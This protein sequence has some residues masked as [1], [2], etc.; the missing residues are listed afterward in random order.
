MGGLRILRDSGIKVHILKELKLHGKMLLADCVAAI[1]GS[2][3][4]A[5]GSL[6]SRRELGI[7]IHDAHAVERLQHIAHRDWN[8]SRPMDLSDEGLRDDLESRV[9]GVRDQDTIVIDSLLR[10]ARQL[11]GVSYELV[12]FTGFDR[13][14]R[15]APCSRSHDGTGRMS[16]MVTRAR[17]SRCAVGMPPSICVSREV[18]TAFT[19]QERAQRIR[20]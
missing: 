6:D 3:N 2:M 15:N 18:A 4:P 14:C 12:Y 8:Y 17:P 16:E 10:V 11:R 7:E 13:D 19:R 5:P 20:S 9:E 1:V